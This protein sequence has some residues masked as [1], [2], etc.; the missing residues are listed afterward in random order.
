MDAKI[1]NGL[2][3]AYMGDCIY[4][5]YIREF[6]LKMGYNKVRDLHKHAVNFTSGEAQADIIHNILSDNILSEDEIAIFK[7]GRNSHIN[8]VRKNIKL[9]DYLDATGFEALL[10]YLYLDNQKER[11]EQLIDY[12]IKKRSGNN[13]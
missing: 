9:Q 11:L 1:L 4:E 8:S 13:D 12:S 6:I 7:R 10:G 5:L 2:S 3:L